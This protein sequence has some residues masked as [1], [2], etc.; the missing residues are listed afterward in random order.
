MGSMPLLR[1]LRLAWHRA[2][3]EVLAAVLLVVLVLAALGAGAQA[4]FAQREA[5]RADALAAEARELACLARNVYFEARGEPEAG[6]YAVAEVTLNRRGAARYPDTICEVVHQKNWDPLRGR[7]VGAFSWT[8]FDVLPAPRGDEWARAQKVA[9]DVY[10][11]RAAPRLQ[12]ALY[13]HASYI[14][15]AW[16]KEKTPVARIG[17]HVFYR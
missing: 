3:R 5:V 17:R 11:R 8:E 1:S 9:E 6:Q 7:Y 12:G 2:D 16:A 15:P 14:K 13:F 10:F 4:V